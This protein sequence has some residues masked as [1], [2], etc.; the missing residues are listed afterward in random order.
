[1]TAGRLSRERVQPGSRS[2]PARLA[3]A[4]R[5]DCGGVGWGFESGRPRRAARGSAHRAVGDWGWGFVPCPPL[6]PPLALMRNPSPSNTVRK[7]RP[8]ST[9][10]RRST[11]RRGGGGEVGGGLRRAA[12]KSGNGAAKGSATRRREPPAAHPT[13]A[14]R[15]GH[16]APAPAPEP[17]ALRGGGMPR[18]DH[19]TR[20]SKRSSSGL[21]LSM[22]AIS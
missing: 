6:P 4:L 21:V 19:S 16:A 17:S 10:K 11:W 14:G 2:R 20:I 8:M 18:R 5:W 12:A 3:T 7:L 15:C 1:M 9:M 13:F 22:K